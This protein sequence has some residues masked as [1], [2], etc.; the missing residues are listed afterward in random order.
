MPENGLA[1]V[2]M[3]DPGLAEAGTAGPERLRGWITTHARHSADKPFIESIEQGKA[4]TYAQF[5]ALAERLA[6]YLDR[7]GIA[8]NDRIALLSNNS[9]EHLAIYVGVMAY[10]ATICTI[11]IEMNAIHLGDI[12]QRLRPRLVLYENGIDLERAA[13]ETLGIPIELGSW[14]LEGGT[15]LFATLE[16]APGAAAASKILP[17][18]PDDDACICF[19]SGTAAKPKGVVLSFSELLDNV[20]PIAHAFGMKPSDR[21]LDYRSYNWASAQILSC[22]APLASG[23]TLIMARRFSVNRFFQWVRDYGATIA[24]GN[25]TVI[26][27]LLN[28]PGHVPVEDAATLRFMT[29]SSASL[30]VEQWER[31]EQQFGVTI[32]QGYGSSETGWIAASR[33]DLRRLGSVGQPLSYHELAIV[34][35]EGHRLPPQQIGFVEV[36]N[37]RSRAYRYLA[38][39]GTIQRSAQG[40]IRTGDMGYVDADGFLYLTGRDNDLI[41][42][43]GV[44]IAPTEIDGV[45]AACDGIAEAATI[46]VPD[47]IHGEEIVSYVVAKP[48]AEITADGVLAYCTRKLPAAKMPKQILFRRDLPKTARGKLDRRRLLTEWEKR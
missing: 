32:A 29:S 24:A 20:L 2:P 3:V 8:R 42:R 48:G 25:P 23:A 15:G 33:G 47:A 10:G 7:Q 39:D 35:E 41:I 9:L 6:C 46:G 11:N 12:L 18:G 43:G 34:G 26:N 5:A 4:I 44:N 13:N 16:D 38:E 19:T 1:C 40:R 31:F 21:I 14:G 37:R 28:R 27:M 36:G 17:A 22:L 45:L 30:A